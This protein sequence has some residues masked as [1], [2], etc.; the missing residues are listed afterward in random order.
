MRT[1]HCACLGSLS[2]NDCGRI[3]GQSQ[4]TADGSSTWCWDDCNLADEYARRQLLAGAQHSLQLVQ[5]IC[6]LAWSPQRVTESL[7]LHCP[8]V[9]WPRGHQRPAPPGCCCAPHAPV[10]RSDAC[11]HP[12]HRL[13][14]LRHSAVCVERAWHRTH[15]PAGAARCVL[16]AA[17]GIAW[18]RRVRFVQ[19]MQALDWS[20]HVPSQPTKGATM[21]LVCMQAPQTAC[22]RTWRRRSRRRRPLL[23]ATPTQAL[24]SPCDW[25]PWAAC[26][27]QG[28]STAPSPAPPRLPL[29]S[30]STT[31]M[32]VCYLLY[33]DM[34]KPS[35]F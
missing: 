4:P 34:R 11:S 17:A 23:L 20:A 9:P 19:D 5:L 33:H 26:G 12:E 29:L 31:A 21:L 27:A 3:E 10:A 15:V 2:S 6:F 35:R 28:C 18:I 13:Q 30:A 7:L 22:R 1:P 8:G 14:H 16:W 32:Q 24:P 25:A